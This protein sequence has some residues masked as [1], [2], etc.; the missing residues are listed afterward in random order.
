MKTSKLIKRFRPELVR[1][2]GREEATSLIDRGQLEYNRLLMEYAHLPDGVMWHA[3]RAIIPMVSIY[4]QLHIEHPKEALEIAEI[5]MKRRAESAG[6]RL[7]LLLHIP[8]AK[9]LTMKVLPWFVNRLY[10]QYKG[11][12]LKFLERSEQ[13]MSADITRCPYQVLT[14]RMRCPELCAV[15]CHSDDYAYGNLSGIRFIR[16]GTLGTG[17]DKCDFRV[18][19]VQ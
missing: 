15:F 19:R 3:K 2:Y 1:R 6:R 14:A 12:R 5:V 10:G 8:G 18:E 17:A 13:A 11:F 7:D 4:R 9:K 16:S